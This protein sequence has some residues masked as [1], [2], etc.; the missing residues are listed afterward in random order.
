MRPGFAGV[1]GF[2]NAITRGEIGA[3]QSFATA[4]VNN[5]WIGRSNGEGADGAGRLVVENRIPGVPEI[6]GL[7][8][9]AVDRRHVEDIRLMRHAGDGHGTA[10]TERADAAPAHFRKEF[11]I[12][13]RR[14]RGRGKRKTKNSP[15]NSCKNNS[16][17]EPLPCRTDAHPSPPGEKRGYS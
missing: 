15:E 9:A 11:L 2:V 5:V 12:P 17:A 14:V 10:S 8:R 13:L 6:G 3:L 16:N 4:H 1:G 7:P